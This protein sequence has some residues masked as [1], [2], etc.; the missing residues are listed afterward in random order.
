MESSFI[1][2]NF[3]NTFTNIFIKISRFSSSKS[4]LID[5]RRISFFVQPT[6]NYVFDQVTNKS[7]DVQLS[8]GLINFGRKNEI[9]CLRYGDSVEICNQQILSLHNV[10]SKAQSQVQTCAMLV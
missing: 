7:L 1:E 10:V 9:D 4:E 8:H 5:C 2:N 3:T 6:N